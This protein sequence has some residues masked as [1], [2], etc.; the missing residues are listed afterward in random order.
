MLLQKL[1]SLVLIIKQKSWQ[2]KP[3]SSLKIDHLSRVIT[4]HKTTKKSAIELEII[5]FEDL[6]R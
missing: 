1:M 2:K 5:N 6:P 4:E 3:A